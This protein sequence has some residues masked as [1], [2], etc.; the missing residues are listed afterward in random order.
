MYN[1]LLFM[2]FL[3][4]CMT[5]TSCNIISIHRGYVEIAHIKARNLSKL[6]Q[7][8]PNALWNEARD[9]LRAITSP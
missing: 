7:V 9:Y 3:L 8:I 5:Y 4:Y 2:Q 6:Q 1:T